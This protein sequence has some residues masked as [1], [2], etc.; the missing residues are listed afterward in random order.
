MNQAARLLIKKYFDQ[1]SFVGSSIESFNQFI[2]QELQA[3][4]EENKLIEPTIIPPN[5]DS[6]K[7]KLDK[8][9]VTKPELTEA[10]GSKRNIYPVEARLRKISYAAPIFLEVSAHINE[11]Q[12]E[13]F[14][15]QIGSLPVMLKSN[16][17]HLNKLSREELI[18][19]GE[20]PDD[21]GGYFIINGTERVLVNI[22]DL[23]S[24]HVL[25]E[26]AS[27]GPSKFVG[28]LFSE[29][30]SYK[31]P[32]SLE[33]M[34]DGLF[35][36][37]FTRVRR[38][39]LIVILKA[40]GLLKDE[41]I[42]TSV[43]RERQF[44]ELLVNLFDHVG[45][46]TP[47]DA[48]DAVAKHM[49]ITQSKEIRNERVTE[50]LDKYLLPHIGLRKEDRLAKAYNLCKML[51]KYLLVSNAEAPVDNK[52]HYMNK[53]IKLAGDLLADLFRVN[54]KVLIGDMMYNFQ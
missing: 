15:T 39:P 44:D 32:H 18:A 28:K 34:K 14:T 50:L 51:R 35:Y 9:W 22:E 8:I 10:D 5:V 12:R 47:D 24:N 43:S 33:Q 53:R 54:L 41:D 48:L 17:C 42:M 4:I 40:L 37:T 16:Y 36:L 6:F 19:K 2:D 38:V 11:V 26:E 52:D 27:T 49:G 31:I 3:I 20:D 23:S 21:A 1:H 46:K 13:T 30:G 29:S 25:V 7:I 45:I